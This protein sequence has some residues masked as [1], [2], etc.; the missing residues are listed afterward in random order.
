MI[1]IVKIGYKELTFNTLYSVL[2][3]NSSIVY[4]LS[5]ERVNARIKEKLSY[6]YLKSA[7]IQEPLNPHDVIFYKEYEKNKQYRIVNIPKKE[8]EVILLK[9]KLGGYLTGIIMQ[10][11][12]FDRAFE[13]L[14]TERMIGMIK[15][16][17][18]RLGLE[19]KQV[20]VHKKYTFK[21]FGIKFSIRF[22]R[23]L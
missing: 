19:E 23:K 6:Y 22:S 16:A 4:T 3:D 7:L 10:E 8:L 17:S 5:K 15:N 21:K 2:L 18:K 1:E 20:I 11:Q 14:Y 9:N 13:E 12:E